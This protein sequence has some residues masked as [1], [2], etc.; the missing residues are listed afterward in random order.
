MFKNY[1]LILGVPVD[2]APA[3]IRAA[4]RELAK[5]Y[6]P[7]H[8]SQEAD[9]F[10]DISEAY[11]VL[12]DPNRRASFDREL[13]Q[14]R[15]AP[16]PRPRRGGDPEPLVSNTMSVTGRPERLRP[17]FDAL[18]E[19][20]ARNFT[21]VH[22]PK[23]EH[24]EPLDFE[25]ILSPEEAARGVTVPFEIPVFVVCSWCAG[26]GHGSAGFCERCDGEGRLTDPRPLDVRIPADV[27]AGA[28]IEVSLTD[29]GV[30]NLW[31]RVHVRV[32]HH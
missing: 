24:A 13:H 20:F 7:D 18:L 25:L 11:D 8:G 26:S 30:E 4:F 17:S 10:R 27:R 29:L 32:A 28:V 9:A 21:G 16:P 1:Y 14:R 23:S 5:R 2:A 22:V 19:R 3:A 31:L 15:P 6:H 12:S